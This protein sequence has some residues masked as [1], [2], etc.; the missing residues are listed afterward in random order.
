MRYLR[1][2]AGGRPAATHLFVSPKKVGQKGDP[3][4]AA[5]AG[6]PFVQYKKWETPET[7]C[8]QTRAFLNPFSVLHKRRLHMGNSESQKQGQKQQQQQQQHQIQN[9][10]YFTF[11][12]NIFI[13]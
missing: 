8:A 5:P 11:K 2:Q 1:M 13:K 6:F 3:G 9:P 7:R 12:S 10:G 4:V